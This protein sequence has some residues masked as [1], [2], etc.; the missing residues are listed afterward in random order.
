MII[1]DLL[2]DNVLTA[3]FHVFL[4]DTMPSGIRMYIILVQVDLRLT[5]LTVSWSRDKL[6]A[7]ADDIF[8]T[9]DYLQIYYSVR[10]SCQSQG[11]GIVVIIP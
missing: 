1:Y 3:L 7:D 9:R 5:S 4:L 8:I 11:H 2:I 6:L 10:E